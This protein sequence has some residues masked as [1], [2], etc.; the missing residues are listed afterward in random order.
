MCSAIDGSAV[1]GRSMASSSSV[2][3]VPIQL[4][5]SQVVLL[6]KEIV[7]RVGSV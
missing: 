7:R 2:K 5:D 4:I 3:R 6:S 1:A